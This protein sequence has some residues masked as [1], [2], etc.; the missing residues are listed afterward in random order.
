MKLLAIDTS[1]SSLSAA[2]AEAT[3]PAAGQP[4]AAN[5]I[6][7]FGVNTGRNHSLALLPMLQALLD[8][9]GLDLADGCFCRYP[10][11]GQLYW[12]AHRLRYRQSLGTGAGKA[13]DWHQQH[14]GLR[15]GRLPGGLGVPDF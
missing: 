13:A 6:G 10:G 12:P 2:I 8:N 3:P 4:L 1:G 14:P 11:T 15:A 5:I 9:C 7:S